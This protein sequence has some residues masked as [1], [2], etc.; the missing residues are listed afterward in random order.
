MDLEKNQYSE[1]VSGIKQQI[2]SAQYAAL[3]AVNRELIQLYWFIGKSIVEKQEEFGWGKAVVE[4][5]AKDLQQEFVGQTG[6]SANNLWRM[7]NFYESYKGNEKLARAVQE[8]GWGHNVAILQ[9]CKDE[10]ER[11]FYVLSTQKFGWSRD[12]LVN[13]IENKTFERYLLNQTNFD[14]TV[15]KSIKTQAHLA[16]KDHYVFDFLS[17][18]EEHTEKQLEEAILKNIRKFLIEMGGL[19][20]YVG[21]QFHIKVSDYDY[22]V[23]LLLYHR[24]LQ[25]LVAV[26]LKIGAY[27][28]E[29]KGQIEFYLAVLN[30]K[31]KMPHENDSIGIII[32][33]TKDKT[34]VEYSLKNSN[35]PIGVATYNTSSVLPEIYKHL[36]PS[37]EEFAE[38]LKFIEDITQ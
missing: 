35:M 37:P 36:L 18:S 21:N 30:D 32:C 31:Y 26:E 13:K 29:Y 1:F 5:L 28:P 17:L 3:K 33:Q 22:Y 27:K 19:F 24:Q 20:T 7:R 11:L 9:K 14:E 16:I 2:R 4:T 38:K 10:S 34:I 6:F 12:L 15:Q 8:I 25:C 23:D